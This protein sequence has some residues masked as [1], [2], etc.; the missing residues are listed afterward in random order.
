MLP[1]A[2]AAAAEQRLQDL[3]EGLQQVCS[4]GLCEICLKQDS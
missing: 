1:Q 3:K 2:I 4:M